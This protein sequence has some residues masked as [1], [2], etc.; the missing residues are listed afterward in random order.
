MLRVDSSLQH[1]QSN[2]EDPPINNTPDKNPQNPSGAM[3]ENIPNVRRIDAE[4]V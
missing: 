2:G 3:N 4:I 1:L